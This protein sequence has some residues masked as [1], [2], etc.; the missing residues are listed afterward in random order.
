[1]TDGC[2]VRARQH[3]PAGQEVLGLVG[4]KAPL[5]KKE[6][7]RLQNLDFDS[8]SSDVKKP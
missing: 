6:K 4:Y 2:L 7:D 1:M 5:T 3:I 8:V